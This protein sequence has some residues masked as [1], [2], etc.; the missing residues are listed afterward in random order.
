MQPRYKVD[1]MPKNE[2]QAS[3]KLTTDAMNVRDAMTLVAKLYRFSMY[4]VIENINKFE[5]VTPKNQ[6]N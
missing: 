2:T 1:S 3:N 4:Y 6:L 5:I